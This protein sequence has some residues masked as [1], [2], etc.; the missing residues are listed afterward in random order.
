MTV[1]ALV[2]GFDLDMTLIDTRPGFAACLVALGDEA[3]I[4]L[5]VEGIVSNLGPPLDLMLARYVPG[6]EPEQV[7]AL[8][9]RFRILYPGI[10]VPP[11]LAFPGAHEALASVRA[12]RGRNL[13]ITGKYAPNARLHLDALGFDVDELVAEVWGPGKG[14][15]LAEHAA[16]IYVGDHVHDVEGALAAGVVS[17][18]VLS[19]GCTEAELRA[20]GTDVVLPELGAFPGWLEEHLLHARLD[21]LEQQ[22]RGLGSVLVAFSGGADSAFLLAAAVR[23]LGAD[24]VAAAPACSACSGSL[25]ESELGPARSFAESLGVRML[26]PATDETEPEGSRRNDGH[27]CCH[28]KGDLLDM[29]ARLAARHGL[30]HVATGTNADDVVAGIRAAT[31]RDA[32]VPLADAGLTRAQ[33]REASRR[34]RLPTWERPP[35]SRPEPLPELLAPACSAGFAA[36]ELD[37]GGSGQGR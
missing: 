8:V 26:T 30:S 18:S 3:G 23:T 12:H 1:P 17:V 10:A 7:N 37:P 31:G 27:R 36:T 25:P 4:E 6:I 32:R 29:L 20:A 21:A 19:G 11:T 5:D 22:L 28:C 24:N 13:V 9:D 33:I 14:P 34:W 35:T 15:A 2:V 16:S